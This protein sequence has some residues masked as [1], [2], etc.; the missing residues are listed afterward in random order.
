MNSAMNIA[1]P[2][3]PDNDIIQQGRAVVDLIQMAAQCLQTSLS[4]SGYHALFA[5]PPEIEN[6]SRVRT[7]TFNHNYSLV[8]IPPEMEMLVTLETLS[9][10]YN[11]IGRLPLQVCK[12]RY[13]CVLDL[14]NNALTWLPCAVERMKSLRV[15][16]L[17]FNQLQTLPTE[18]TQVPSLESLCVE[19][20]PL[21]SDDAAEGRWESN[22]PTKSSPLQEVRRPLG[23]DVKCAVCAM[24]LE[25][26]AYSKEESVSVLFVDIAGCRRVPLMSALCSKKC[27]DQFV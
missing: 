5:I 21:V 2:L 26:S 11:R 16:N 8:E 19:G 12:L 13:L 14:G 20:N 6:L 24:L 4:V 7:L 22:N 9:L 25:R 27:Y 18:M 3:P 15:L 1:L 10:S 17:E 23:E